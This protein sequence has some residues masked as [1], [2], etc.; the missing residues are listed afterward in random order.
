V[1][2]LRNGRGR[3]TSD[4]GLGRVV[5]HVQVV[6]EIVNLRINLMALDPEFRKST[7][8]SREVREPADVVVSQGSLETIHEFRFG[9][10]SAE[11]LGVELW[12]QR[13]EQLFALTQVV[14]LVLG[15]YWCTDGFKFLFKCFQETVLFAIVKD[16]FVIR[17][18]FQ[19][20]M[21]PD[22]GVLGHEQ[23]SQCDHFR[24]IQELFS[25]LIDDAGTVRLVL[26]KSFVTFYPDAEST[27]EKPGG[28]RV[29]A[30]KAGG[31]LNHWA[32]R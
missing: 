15:L 1:E 27:T 22:S 23:E 28:L 29:L 6:L 5:S 3:V 24:F 25:C 20:E 17:E 13:C 18:L 21:S 16:R 8:R 10:V 30:F 31:F 4:R 19:I 26:E 2:E 11:S 14:Q 12:L 7:G 32:A 9:P